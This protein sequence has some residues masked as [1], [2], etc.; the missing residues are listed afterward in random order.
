[1]SPAP[2]KIC[3][4]CG[5]QKPLSAFL[6]LT[7]PQGR[8]YGSICSSCR[9]ANIDKQQSNESIDSATSTSGHKIDAKA[10]VHSDIEKKKQYQNVEEL[11]Q[12]DRKS[13]EERQ[14]QK[15]LK[16]K[17]IITN[18]QKHRTDYLR[19]PSFLDNMSIN[20]QLAVD[21]S[22]PEIREAQEKQIDLTV[23]LFLDIPGKRKFDSEFNKVIAWF[24][25]S[26]API[27]KQ[28][29]LALQNAKRKENVNK[30]PN[31]P[32]EKPLGPQPA[33]RK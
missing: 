15:V 23:P 25:D 18:E 27:A 13:A 31:E 12:E 32:V 21:P 30:K 10:K 3:S 5:L 6:Q 24:G 29:M 8:T 2:T 11:Y 9:K 7:G 16:V 17:T 19:K 33:R 26:G 28:A 4:S 14:S 22:S 1:V 20:K